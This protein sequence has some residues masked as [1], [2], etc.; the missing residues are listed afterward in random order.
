MHYTNT[1]RLQCSCMYSLHIHVQSIASP[2]AFSLAP[3][4]I[5][6]KTKRD[7]VG[8]AINFHAGWKRPGYLAGRYK[9][10]FCNKRRLLQNV[11]SC[12]AAYNQGTINWKI[13]GYILANCSMPS[14][15]L[16]AEE[17]VHWSRAKW[18][19]KYLVS[20]IVLD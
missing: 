3:H 17:I 19:W 16:Q 7:Y 4:K 11:T 5:S 6:R 15:W 8:L 1:T 12:T 18:G 2:Q 10:G 13:D 9:I 20:N 14:Q